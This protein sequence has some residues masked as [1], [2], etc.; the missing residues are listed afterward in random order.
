M[1]SSALFSSSADLQSVADGAR[2]ILEPETSDSV[3]L[4]QAALVALGFSLPQAGIDDAF[5]AE[6]GAAVSAFKRSRGLSPSDPVVGV[7]TMN[8][9]DF[10]VAYLEGAASDAH[11]A[12]ARA[13][14]A[15][16]FFAGLVELQR[17]DLDL[18]RV[19]TDFFEFGNRMCFRMSFGLSAQAAALMG[20]IV[21]PRVFLDYCT[22]QAPCTSA[23][24]FDRNPGST[25]Y[26]DFLL[27]QHPGIDP[28]QL[29]GL[30]ALKR[31]DI[32]RHRPQG[33]E[34]YEIK[35]MS[36][37][38]AIAA[39]IKLSEITTSYARLGLPYLPGNR[40][41]PTEFIPLATMFTPEGENLRVVLHLMRRARGLI[42]WEICIEGDYV[43]YFNRVRIVAGLLAI[44]VLLAELA[45]P[46]AEA[47]G[48]VAALRAL[49]A[50]LGVLLPAL[51]AL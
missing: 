3:A 18:T 9:L 6:T 26:V 8:R 44:L 42:F 30:G 24:F 1:L 10:E 45:I 4:I 17:P 51:E 12:D 25:E 5:G 36:L 39:R 37:S 35:P 21:E 11:V 7:G 41:T 40:Y 47:A 20:R 33:S 29:G 38:G 16:P 50:E 15:D 28:A 49:A 27:V 13:L 34:W 31:P 19:L 22:R 48:V 32:L 23:D 2:R 46:A 14:A 43:V